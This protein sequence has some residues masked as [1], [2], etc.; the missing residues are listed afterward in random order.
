[1]T[2]FQDAEDEIDK[3]L[4]ILVGERSASGPGPTEPPKPRPPPN[5][6]DCMTPIKEK[7]KQKKVLDKERVQEFRKCL[8]LRIESGAEDVDPRKV[9]FHLKCNVWFYFNVL[10]L[11]F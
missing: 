2:C 8:S 11:Y 6:D 7:I 5:A 1:M 3:C 10:Y 9:N 4:S